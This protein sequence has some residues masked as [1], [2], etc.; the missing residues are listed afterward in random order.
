MRK[1][2]RDKTVGRWL[3]SLLWIAVIGLVVWQLRQSK[4]ESTST[5]TPGA[6]T[7]SQLTN[8]VESGSALQGSSLPVRADS[9]QQ[10]AKPVE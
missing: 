7:G 8:E 1:R 2:S 6:A 4:V 3:V 10:T 9:P 5:L